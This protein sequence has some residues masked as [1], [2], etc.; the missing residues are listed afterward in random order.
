MLSSVATPFSGRAA[1]AAV[2]M[3]A[4]MV[5]YDRKTD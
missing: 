5:R 4:Y 3:S 2:V 1:F